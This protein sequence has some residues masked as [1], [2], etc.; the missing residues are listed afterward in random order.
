MTTMTREKIL[1]VRLS[2]EEWK[3]LN[4]Y[5]QFKQYSISEVIRDYIKSMKAE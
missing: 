3:K 4:M 5:A 1:R 2:D